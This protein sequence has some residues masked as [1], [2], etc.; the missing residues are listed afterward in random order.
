MFFIGTAITMVGKAIE[1]V[2]DLADEIVIGQA[3]P[4]MQSVIRNRESLNEQCLKFSEVR[5]KSMGIDDL[6]D[7]RNVDDIGEVELV[8]FVAWTDAEM[9][10]FDRAMRQHTQ[11]DNRF[12]AIT[13]LRSLVKTGKERSK[14]IYEQ[15]DK[16][17][18]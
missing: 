13:R 7:E 8:F 2:I 10:Q 12:M 18:W 14:H 1:G 4:V 9:A 15:M 6:A 5:C 17:G 11:P 16:N 3:P